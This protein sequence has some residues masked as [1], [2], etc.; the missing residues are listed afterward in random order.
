MLRPHATCRKAPVRASSEFLTNVV[1][2]RRSTFMC[3][4]RATSAL[5]MIRVGR[6]PPERGLTARRLRPKFASTCS[7]YVDIEQFGRQLSENAGNIATLRGF[8]HRGG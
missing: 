2:L 8:L 5:A 4:T 7:R 6:Q 3:R 1:A